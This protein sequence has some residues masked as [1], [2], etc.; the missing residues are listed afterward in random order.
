MFTLLRI[1]LYLFL[2]SL[3][4]S[5]KLEPVKLVDP[6]FTVK[7]HTFFNYNL[8]LKVIRHM[9][10]CHYTNP[11]FKP[12]SFVT[13]TVEAKVDDTAPKNVKDAFKEPY[14]FP[15]MLPDYIPLEEH[16]DRAIDAYLD[17]VIHYSIYP[18]D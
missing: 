6:I 5:R 8:E 7:A 3:K 1:K 12:K 9:Y 17:T 14:T 15:S 4:G 11:L 2:D 13:F 10:T 18:K 16:V